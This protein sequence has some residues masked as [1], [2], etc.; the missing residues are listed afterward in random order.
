MS[1]DR[2]ARKQLYWV[3]PVLAA[4]AVSLPYLLGPHTVL[5]ADSYRAYDWL[6]AAKFRWYIRD[7]LL[8]GGGLPNWNPYLEG[9][10]PALAHPTDGSLS[11]FFLL[12]LV[13]GVLFGLKVDAVLLLMAGAA[14][15]AL[16]A[17]SWLRLP[18][19]AACVAG[20]GYAVAGWSPSRV[21]VG[22]YES[23]W[24]GITPLL[25]FLLLEATRRGWRDGM[26]RLLGATFL[27]ACAGTQ[28]QLCLAFAA[29]QMALWAALAR[30]DVRP[31]M[32]L[33]RVGFLLAGTAGLGAIKFLP[34][35]ELVSSRGWRTES[36]PH[37]VG[38]WDGVVG[39]LLGLVRTAAPTGTYDPHGIPWA[40][41][42]EYGGLGLIVLALGLLGMVRTRRGRALGALV[43]ITASLGWQP[44]HGQQLNL[45]VLLRHLPIFD[46]MR[47]TARYV[48]FFLVLWI[49]LAAGL[50][51][52]EIMGRTRRQQL[53]IGILVLALLPGAWTSMELHRTTFRHAVD[54][55]PEPAET[56]YSIRLLTVP[57]SGNAERRLLTWYAQQAGVAVHYRPEDMPEVPEA[58]LEA[59]WHVPVEGPWRRSAKWRGEAW[60]ADGQGSVLSV[61]PGP[62]SFDLDVQL[63]LP[64]LIALNQN[65]H[66][67]WR[68][69]SPEGALVTSH[70][71]LL[72]VRLPEAH[73]GPVRLVF[74]SRSMRL[75]GL[76]S[77]LFLGGLIFLASRP[78]H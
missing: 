9:G 75:G 42:Y 55:R 23:L 21:A 62:D 66:R 74:R 64:S 25:L 24:F 56:F 70:Q 49:C 5:H 16:L 41:E 51:W 39:S 46:A 77:L 33:Q 53:R 45:F 38:L 31:G 71:G 6:E 60:I 11:P 35:L 72:A 14:G 36:A 10:L 44:G 20:L 13:F 7:T 1:E 37:G 28:M 27:L 65:F 52:Q 78:K 48:E 34:M 4:L 63:E 40:N 26:S 17:R 22:F 3:I 73:L 67:D 57:S 18:A 32:L 54:P 30:C 43:L 50:G 69:V 76:I 61:R 47:D 29:L 8:S 58:A 59:R 2:L 19:E 12:H 15:T 68:A